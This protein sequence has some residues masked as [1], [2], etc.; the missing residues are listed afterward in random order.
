MSRRKPHSGSYRDYH[1]KACIVAPKCKI[2]LRG[3]T[4]QERSLQTSPTKQ[5]RR[6]V[7]IE[8]YRQKY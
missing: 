4:L 7:T 8:D 3:R 1:L 5:F 6:V 2:N